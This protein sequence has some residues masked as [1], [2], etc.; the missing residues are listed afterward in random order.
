MLIW[1][2]KELTKVRDIIDAACALESKEEGQEFMQLYIEDSGEDVARSN[3][4][5][6]T[7]YL[8]EET[9]K[10]IMDFCSVT[11]PIFGDRQV[12]S[13]EA[14]DEGVKRGKVARG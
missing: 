4:G 6:I 10:R 13:Q 2:E 5:Y 1:K 8:D 12:T 7:G 11:H 9:A 3:V 14:F